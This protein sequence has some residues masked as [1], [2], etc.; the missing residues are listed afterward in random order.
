[1]D[2]TKILL[3]EDHTIVREGIRELLLKKPEFEVVGEAQDGR[4]AV[5]LASSLKPDV[6]LMDITMPTLDGLAATREIKKKHPEIKILILTIHDSEE[7]IYQILKYGADGYVLKEAAYEELVTAIGAVADGKKYL[8][9]RISG[10]VISRYVKGTRPAKTPLDML[11]E[12]E[13][14]VLG[15]IAEGYK[16]REIAEKL[17]IS[18]K[19]VEFHRLNLMKKLDIHNQA[20]LIRFAI[21]LGILNK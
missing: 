21:R 11:T 17:F 18:V 19:T 16:N 15:L 12:K 10:E 14:E 1:M 3:A 6:I 13:K 2:K 5:K 4:E 7:Y 8:S 9:P 20:A